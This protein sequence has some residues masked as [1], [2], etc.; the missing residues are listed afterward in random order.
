MRWMILSPDGSKVEFDGYHVYG[1]ERMVDVCYS[2][3]W[4]FEAFSQCAECGCIEEAGRH[5]RDGCPHVDEHR[6]W[7]TRCQARPPIVPAEQ[8]G[9]QVG[10]VK[11]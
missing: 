7:C 8:P 11:G 1:G 3:D 10:R 6:K 4:G 5:H 9:V 2:G